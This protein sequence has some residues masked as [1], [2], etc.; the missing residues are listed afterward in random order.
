MKMAFFVKSISLFLVC[1]LTLCLGWRS[2][3]LRVEMR[4]SCLKSVALGI[5]PVAVGSSLSDPNS[6]LCLLQAKPRATV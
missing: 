2:I 3:G 6:Y 5:Y 4:S 1:G